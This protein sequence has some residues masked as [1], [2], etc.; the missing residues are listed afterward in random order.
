MRTLTST[1][2]AEG[3]AENCY[4]P[5]LGSSYLPFSPLQQLSGE[6]FHAIQENEDFK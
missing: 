6:F 3:R 1:A 5:M 4:Q 2:G